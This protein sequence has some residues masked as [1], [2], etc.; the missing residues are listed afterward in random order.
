MSTPQQIVAQNTTENAVFV[1]VIR[2]CANCI[3]LKRTIDKE[4]RR[5]GY[6]FMCVHVLAHCAACV[7]SVLSAL[8]LTVFVLLQGAG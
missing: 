7:R 3:A 8:C 2:G 6:K 5:S 1:F 4:Y